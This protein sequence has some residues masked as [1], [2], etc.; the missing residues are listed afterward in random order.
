M[1]AAEKLTILIRAADSAIAR[2]DAG[3]DR[4]DPAIRTLQAHIYE[5]RAD[6]QAKLDRRSAA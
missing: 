5:V 4:S 2:I 3:A 6:A 1:T